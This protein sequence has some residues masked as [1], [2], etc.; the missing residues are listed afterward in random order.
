ARIAH[1]LSTFYIKN[2]QDLVLNVDVPFDAFTVA[3]FLGQP[4]RKPEWF[5]CCPPT[6]PFAEL[7]PAGTA[8]LS[9]PGR[10]R[11]DRP[12]DAGGDGAG[13]DALE[14][15]LFGQSRRIGALDDPPN[16]ESLQP[17]AAS[18]RDLQVVDRSPVRRKSARHRRPLPFAARTRHCPVRRRKEPDSGA[19]SNAAAFA[20][21]PRPSRAAHA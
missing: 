2:R 12:S 9:T 4:P 7:L 10:G 3:G 6:V 21:A 5:L 18:R 13:R 20:H 11:G 16:L 14:L 19:R 15:A 17:S 8:V 1:V